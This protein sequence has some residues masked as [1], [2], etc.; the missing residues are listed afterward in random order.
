MA[1]CLCTK[2]NKSINKHTL[3][4]KHVLKEHFLF[5]WRHIYISQHLLECIQ[6]RLTKYN[7]EREFSSKIIVSEN[8]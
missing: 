8:S 6:T 7:D 2:C 5:S 1:F 4:Y 3:K